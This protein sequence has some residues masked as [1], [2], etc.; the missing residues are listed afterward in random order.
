[1]GLLAPAYLP[2]QARP[3]WFARSL[4]PL[5]LTNYS[6]PWVQIHIPQQQHHRLE[7]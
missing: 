5:D 1:M 2:T 6:I 7:A 3:K 4:A